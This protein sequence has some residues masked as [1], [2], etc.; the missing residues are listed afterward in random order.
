MDGTRR[1]GTISSKA[2]GP[3]VALFRGLADPTRLAILQRL[4]RGEMRVADLVDEL[5]LAQSTVSGHLACLR[6]CGL[7]DSRP[8]GRQAFYA[9]TRTELVDLLA[10][11]ESLL[12]A[13][14]ESVALCSK[15]GTK[16]R[17]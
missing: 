16:A 1:R 6:E 13:T 11:A 8:V 15:Y 9:L 17:R 4:A 3:A 2:L 14:G 5:Q 12:A 7:V 10:A